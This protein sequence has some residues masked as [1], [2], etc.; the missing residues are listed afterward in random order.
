M[1]TRPSKICRSRCAFTLIELLVVVAIIGALV[2]L[3]LPAVQAAREAARRTQCMNHLKQ[4]GLA[5]VAFSDA[6]Q[7]PVGCVGC[8]QFPAGRLTSWNTHLLPYLE[9]Q[10]LLDAYDFTQPARSMGN[11][12]VAITIAEFLC[13]S[14]DSERYADT[15][16]KWSNCGYTDY[17]GIY[18]LEGSAAG[19]GYGIDAASFGVLVYDQPVRL[20]DITDGLSHTLAV[21]ELLNRRI[22]ETVWINGHNVFAQE[23]TTPIN[24]PS[25]LG[26][27]LGSAH[28][29]G[30]LAVACEGHVRWLADAT[31]Q[32][33]LNAWLTRAGEDHAR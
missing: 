9:Q 5:L 6:G 20:A 18:G 22:P 28:P 25:S 23:A 29:G 30:A 15:S 32:P 33:V 2:G 7:L 4:V 27:D 3:L 16:A 13:P 17:G 8:D 14:D 24:A 26:G 31:P 12:A 21:A 11:R 10:A 19:A 1:A